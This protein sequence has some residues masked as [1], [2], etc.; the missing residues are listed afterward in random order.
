ME[1][2]EKIFK[3]YLKNIRNLVIKQHVFFLP[4]FGTKN[5]QKIL[6]DLHA[7]MKLLKILKKYRDKI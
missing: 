3:K 7:R 2:N 5:N 4:S 6:A 1:N